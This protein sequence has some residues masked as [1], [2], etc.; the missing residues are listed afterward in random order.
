MATVAGLV[1]AAGG[2]SR[3]GGPKALARTPGGEPW[4]AHA[5]GTLRAGGCADVVVVLGAAAAEARSLVPAGAQVVTADRWA[6]GMGASLAAGLAALP[7]ATAV[8]ITLVDLPGLP[9]PVVQRLLAGPVHPAV[10]RRATYGGRPGHPVLVGAEYLVPLA[11]T[12]A[13]DRGGRAY[14]DR[15]GVERVECGDLFDGADVDRGAPGEEAQR[16]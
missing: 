1:L 2:G 11:A 15:H 6:D 5:V 12:L 10:L 3:F 7:P 16:R 9:V 4:V 14:L 8:L 13:G